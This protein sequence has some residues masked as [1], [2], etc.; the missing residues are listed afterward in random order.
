MNTMPTRLPTLPFVFFL[1]MT[2]L[3]A[4][5]PETINFWHVG[6][7]DDILMYRRMAVRFEEK[8][9]IRVVVTPLGWNN[10][11]QKYLTAL[12]AQLPP[13][14]GSTNTAGPYEYGRVAGVV[15]LAK[16][17][18]EDLA[19]LQSEI[20]PDLWPQYTF[21]GKT[22]G[23]PH[24][25]TTLLLFYRKDI[26][27]KLGLEP[28]ATWSEMISVV[29][30]LER[31]NYQFGYYWTRDDAWAM[32]TWSFPFGATRYTADGLQ[33]MWN[34]PA[35][36]HGAQFAMRLW[37]LHNMPL[38]KS[39]KP[40]ELFALAENDEGL[41]QPMF[42]DGA[43]RYMEIMT[44][45]PGLRNQW[46]IAPPPAADN[47]K[48][49]L[50]AGGTALVIF[51]L[52]PHKAAAMKW[53][54]FIMSPEMQLEALRDHL[55]NRGDRSELYTAPSRR[56][57][58]LYDLPLDSGTTQAIMTTL[59]RIGTTPKVAGELQADRI[60]DKALKQIRGEILPFLRQRAAVFNLSQWDYKRAVAAG[61]Y[62]QEKRLLHAFVDSVT[63]A[64]LTAA[65]PAADAEL[66]RGREEFERYYRRLL[67]NIEQR[68]RAFDIMDWAKASALLLSLLFIIALARQ[69]TARQAWRSYL[70][71]APAVVLL[72]VFLFIPTIVSIYLSFTNYNPIMPLASADWVGLKN[73]INILR[74]ADL[75][76]SLGRS[77]YY[78][79]LL[80]PVQLIVGVII[81][82]GLDQAL[83]PDRLF[84][85]AFFS[86]LMTSLVSV[87]LIWTALY[88]GTAYGWIN[89]LLLKLGLIRDPISF[90][91]DQNTFL[92]CVIV[93]SIWHG[94]AFV[95]L[96]NLAGLQNIP[97]QIYEAAK[98]DGANA[99]QQFFNIT[100][101]ALKPQILFL[102]IVGTIGAIQVF[103]QIY[104]FGGT[105][106]EGGPKFGPA[107]SGM[108]MVP[109]IFRK[110]FE[111]FRM[112][113]ASA[114]A[115]ILFAV[116][117]ALSFFNWKF[118]TR[119][120]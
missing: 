41:L 111:D 76:Q 2:N 67:D 90:L 36:I 113:E 27:A 112:G 4:N 15:D 120:N 80:I 39:A 105:A 91:Q 20:F 58:E 24:Q 60:L 13:D 1:L 22:F 14:I 51:R 75:W 115:Y 23:I 61:R 38:D 110:G 109:L 103:E 28:P 85:F 17:F 42:I 83:K 101:P 107:D 46:G 63:A 37:N 97:Q 3:F 64:K 47:G 71:L 54:R 16:E 11:E 74:S 45:A 6:T 70:Y 43:W 55:F 52:S 48:T 94:L 31:E 95:I 89:A 30:A 104:L 87:A 35:F 12:A 118:R 93:L 79:V 33:T 10:F 96:I 40:V 66:A 86:P 77:L 73:Y 82:V 81:A 69:R 29:E 57:F 117:S 18:P 25:V 59:K 99:V 19:A 9:G 21:E 50:V 68:K 49:R 106:Q 84:K 56:M 26:F 8:T 72:V 65:K 116:I 44:K 62:P 34:T 114:V 98:I 119:E 5:E 53:A 102:V 32:D 7:N 78:A 88:L 92:N 108:T 100:L